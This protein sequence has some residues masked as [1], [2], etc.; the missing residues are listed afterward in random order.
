VPGDQLRLTQHPAMNRRRFVAGA[1]ATVAGGALFGFTN[2]CGGDAGGVTSPPAAGTVRGTVVDMSGR[3]Q[4]LGRIYLL[5]ANGYNAGV[6]ADVDATGSYDFGAVA[7]G[8]YLLRFWGANLGTVPEP[9]ANPVRITVGADQTTTVQFQIAVGPDPDPD[10][11]IYAGDYFFQEQPA[12]ASN[13]TAVVTLGTVVCWYNVGKVAHTVTGGPW[14]DSGP[15][16]PD[17]NFMWTSSQAGTFPYKCSYHGTQMIA[18]LQI[19]P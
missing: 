12:G 1:G 15:I 17:G 4:G 11:E 16:A 14:G 13:G 18:T 10:H 6:F 8:D 9:L 7:A 19:V 2:A 5:R 3:P